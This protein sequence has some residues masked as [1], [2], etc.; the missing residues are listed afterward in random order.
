MK[1]SNVNMQVSKFKI[2]ISN[3]K[4][5]GNLKIQDLKCNIWDLKIISFGPKKSLTVLIFCMV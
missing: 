3:L 4:I 1:V 2:Q 5:Q